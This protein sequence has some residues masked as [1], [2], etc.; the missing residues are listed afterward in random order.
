VS[1]FEIETPAGNNASFASYEFEVNKRMSRRFQLLGSF[2][3]TGQH[4]LLNGVPTN[5]DQA[6]NNYVKDSYWTSHISGTYQAPWHVLI[7][8]ILRMQQGQP[9]DRVLNV[10]GLRVGTQSIVVDPYGSYHYQNIYVFDTRLEKQFIIR[11]RVHLGLFFDA[12]NIFNTNADQTQSATTGIKTT[13]I[14]GT[15][16]SEPLFLSPT[17]VLSPRIFRLGVKFSF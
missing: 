2:Y 16:F 1:Q 10:T 6:I 11:E 3:W 5:P 12:F 8:P 7:S 15:K 14:N 13:T 9:I 4:Y 17:A